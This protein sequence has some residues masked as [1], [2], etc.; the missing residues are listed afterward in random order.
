MKVTII[1]VENSA[2]RSSPCCSAF[3]FHLNRSLWY[4]PTLQH[5]PCPSKHACTQSLDPH[6]KGRWVGGGG[7]ASHVDAQEIQL[8]GQQDVSKTQPLLSSISLPRVPHHSTPKNFP[9]NPLP[10]FSHS[11]ITT[12]THCGPF[13]GIPFI[14]SSHGASFSPNAIKVFW[15][16]TN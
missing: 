12:K 15:S 2:S 3:S 9:A 7:V 6:K 8:S 10:L 16:C 4:P 5:T 14:H 13:A 1:G 11:P